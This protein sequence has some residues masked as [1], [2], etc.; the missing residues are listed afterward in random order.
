[1]KKIL[2]FI[3][4]LSINFC[5]S[6]QKKGE[7]NNYKMDGYRPIWFSLGQESEYG[8]KYCGGF[9][10]YTAKHKSLAIYAPKVDKTFFVYG[11]TIDKDECYLLCMIGCYDHKTGKVCK[12]TV[13]YDKQG[14]TDPHDNPSLLIDKDGYLWVYVAGRGNVRPGYIYRSLKP[15]DCSKFKAISYKEI[16]AYPQPWY[17]EGKGHF[18][19]FTRY[20]GVRRL[21]FKTSPDGIHWNDYHQIASIIPKGDTKSGH[22]QITGHY[23]NKIVTAFDRHLNGN[24]DTRTNLYYLQTTDFGKTWTLADGT[25]I[26]LPITKK[27]SPCRIVDAESTGQNLYIK[28]VNFDKKGNPII[29]YLTSYGHQP[30]PKQGP[31]EWF[32]AHWTGKKWNINY[33][34]KSSGNYDTGSIYV[35]N[36]FWRVI[37]PFIDGAQR[38]GTGGEIESMISR[39]SGKTWKKERLY[40]KDSPRNHGFVRR[41]VKAQDP[42][43]A[44]WADGNTE[45]LAIS[46]LY[47]ADS[48][49][50]VY[51]LPYNMKEEWEKP[52]KMDYNIEK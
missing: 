28:D 7:Y 51:R 24:C 42:F 38:W 49:G 13:V 18:L 30:G 15:Y 36:K 32:V 43:Y 35:E 34:T 44:Y 31:R 1:M 26:S 19:F 5:L 9:G 8:Y 11:G 6:A 29:L 37:A 25:E 27:D 14:V 50:N 41:S 33:I 39:N 20:D 21:F 12:P 10:T 47:F 23:G 52:E 3:L 4:L 22:Y 45:R 16:M 2:F 40:T 17:I 48:K 46:Y